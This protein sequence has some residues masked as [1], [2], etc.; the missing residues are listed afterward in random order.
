MD[1]YFIAAGRTSRNREKTL[2]K[3]W[4]L[5][6]ICP[7]ISSED[8]DRLRNFSPN[9]R[10]IYI[11]GANDGSFKELKQVRQDEYVVDVSNKEVIQIFK[12]CFYIKTE[13]TRLQE[14]LGWDAEKSS[15]ERRLYLY[16]FFLRSPQKTINKR[17]GFFQDAFELSSNQNWLV[18]QRYFNNEEIS[19]AQIRTCSNNIEDFL[20]ITYIENNSKEN[21]PSSSHEANDNYGVLTPEEGQRKSIWIFPIGLKE[22]L[23]I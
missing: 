22:S 19:N 1:V 6:K 5:E 10:S 2:D 23:K 18:G 3:S 16:V 20:G 8:C 7:F 15:D 21:G 4:N 9:G 12:Y 13:D 14:Y 11:W 17:K